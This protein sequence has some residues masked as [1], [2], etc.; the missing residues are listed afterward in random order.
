MAE[1][2]TNQPDISIIIPIYNVEKYLPRCIESAINQTHKNIEIILVDDGSPDKCG[3]IADEYAKKDDRI[4]VI[5]QE[6]KWLSGARNSGLKIANGKYVVFVDSDDYMR[7][8]MCELLFTR[9]EKTNVDFCSYNSRY[10]KEDGS[11][12]RINTLIFEPDYIYKGDEIK[13]F[14]NTL[15]T[16]N[17]INST[18]RRMYNRDFLI[19]NNLFFEESIRLAEDYEY[20]LRLFPCVRSFTYLDDAVYLSIRNTSS[21]TQSHDEYIVDK[22]IEL[23]NY[24]ESFIKRNG[25]YNEKNEQLSAEFFI[26]SLIR[27]LYI[28][29]GNPKRKR[30]EYTMELIN[31]MVNNEK[32][33]FALKLIDL[34][35]MQFGYYGKAMIK[36]IQKKQVKA[37]YFLY[38][39]NTKNYEREV[40]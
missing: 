10:M 38:S 19:Q 21:I 13:Q 33:I 39:K 32:V 9:M 14:Y 35:H 34:S 20:A 23:Y 36:L 15:I 3:Q 31:K 22:L 27:K 7:E 6:N 11:L 29:L 37:I 5:H 24:R 16:S 25:L 26:D 4:T 2:I 12:I 40:W 30:K 8:D 17:A 28:F 1:I 18:V